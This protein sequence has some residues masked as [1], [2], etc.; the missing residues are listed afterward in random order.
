MKKSSIYRITASFLL[1]LTLGGC[2]LNM[3]PVPAGYRL[4]V[5]FASA[6][7]TLPSGF[8]TI[9]YVQFSNSVFSD[10]AIIPHSVMVSTRT[11]AAGPVVMYIDG[12]ATPALLYVGTGAP[13]S[14]NSAFGT[15]VGHLVAIP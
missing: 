12:P 3:K 5:E 8:P 4:V 11:Y 9:V 13:S 7:F 1:S 15:L 2:Y 10:R 14:A 6:E